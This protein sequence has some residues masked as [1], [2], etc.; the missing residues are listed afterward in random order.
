MA[1]AYASVSDGSHESDLAES[2]NSSLASKYESRTS[3]R[4]PFLARAR[5]CSALTLPYLM[6]QTGTAAT[7]LATPFQS[8]GARGVNNLAAKLLLALFPPNAPFFR[9]TVDPFA[10]EKVAPVAGAQSEIEKSLVKIEGAVQRDIEKDNFR[11]TSFEALKHLLICGNV[12]HRYPAKNGDCHRVFHMDSYVVERDHSTGNPVLIVT[13]ETVR[14]ESLTPALRAAVLAANASGG[15][16]SIDGK[17]FD[18]Y[19]GYFLNDSQQWETHQEIAGESVPGSDG[20]YTIDTMPCLAL[21]GLSISGEDWGRSYVEEYLGDLQ[22]L[23]GLAQALV[24][25]AA[26]AARLLFLVNPNGLTDAKECTKAQNGAFVEGVEGDITVLQMQKFAD[27][28]V[29][30]NTANQIK[31]DLE[32]AFI[33]NSAVQ[34]AGER[35]TAEEIRY[36]AQEL[37]QIL[38]GTYSILSKEYQLPIVTRAMARMTKE[39]R[40]PKLPKDVVSPSIIT[41]IEALGRGNDMNRM[42]MAGQ[43]L[44][45]ILGPGVMNTFVNLPEF[46]KRFFVSAQ[47]PIDNLL[48]DPAVLAQEQQQQNTNAVVHNVAP[49]VVKQIGQHSQMM[50]AAQQQQPQQGAPAPQ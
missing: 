11:V 42:A 26:A 2:R 12:L 24:E 1:S 20:T 8:T 5:Q 19:T 28:Q 47:V 15:E 39:N 14:E 37:E 25:G 9:L 23:E 7:D 32:R 34:R 6:P 29:A 30:G 41:G 13:K 35:V 16:E 22:S 46:V 3:D 10:L 44:A 40:I 18:L 45:T 49:E 43:A 33:M 48:K 27:F 21:R 50:L 38:G 17:E 4:G 36:V 31:S